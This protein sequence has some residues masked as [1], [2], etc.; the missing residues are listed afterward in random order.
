MLMGR[1]GE[2]KS[3]KK[4]TKEEGRW[5]VV[6]LGFYRLRPWVVVR[7][8]HPRAVNTGTPVKALNLHGDKKALT[9]TGV[10]WEHSL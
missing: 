2:P 5:E 6:S 3:T 7:R 10:R 4:G 8:K 9:K 1:P